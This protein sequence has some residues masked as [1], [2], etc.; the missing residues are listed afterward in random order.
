MKKSSKFIVGVGNLGLSFIELLVTMAIMAV[1]GTTVAGA[2]YISSKSYTRGA[3]EVNVQEEAQVALNLI[4][5]WVM[6][7]TA[8][9]SPDSHTLK[10]THPNEDSVNVITVYQDGDQLMY[11]V[12]SDP[13]A[14]VLCDY[15]ASTGVTFNSTFDT[16]RNVNV[17]VDFEI[18]GRTYHAAT[19]TTSRN[20][21]FTL[22]STG[23]DVLNLTVPDSTI[24]LEPGMNGDAASYVFNAVVYGATSAPTITLSD[25]SGDIS[26]AVGTVTASGSSV[27]TCPITV[28]SS[29][30]ASADGSFKLTASYTDGGATFSDSETI[31]TLVRRATKCVYTTND[32]G[33]LDPITGPTDSGKAGSVYINQVD[34][35]LT[36]SAPR[37]NAAYDSGTF[38]YVDPSKVEFYLRYDD[39]SA[40]DPSAY[41]LEFAD[42]GSP[43]IKV[44]LNQNITKDIK[45]YVS[46]VHSGSNTITGTNADNKASRLKATPT[47]YTGGGSYVSYFLIKKGGDDPINDVGAGFQRG[48]RAFRLGKLSDAAALEVSQF[49]ATVDPTHY[50]QVVSFEYKK[51]GDSTY[52]ERI[53]VGITPAEQGSDKWQ[54]WGNSSDAQQRLADIFDCDSAYSIRVF[55]DLVSED[56]YTVAKHFE[57][58]G[59]V[60]AADPFIYNNSDGKFVKE[61]SSSVGSVNQPIQIVKNSPNGTNFYVFFDSYNCITGDPYKITSVSGYVEKYKGPATRTTAELNDPNNWAIVYIDNNGQER[62]VNKPQIQGSESYE[63]GGSLTFSDGTTKPVGHFEQ[64][65]FPDIAVTVV[66]NECGA[67]QPGQNGLYRVTYSTLGGPT[68]TRAQI[69]SVGAMPSSSNP[70]GSVFGMAEFSSTSE[71]LGTVYY[72]IKNF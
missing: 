52:S 12:D 54:L 68:A 10:I 58:T 29:N 53:Y 72:E 65:D 25:Q 56:N 4:S 15:L 41:T 39:G 21:D 20:H 69:T 63:H 31:I 38:A 16:N 34:L 55:Y 46:S 60:N 11:K 8:V 23:S 44:T 27:Y 28:S 3:A 47:S 13:N 37:L 45:V 42:H 62:S 5:D 17:S 14:Y 32:Q 48:S 71:N 33:Y 18:K 6:D 50:L 24:V 57:S 22:N 26:A 7:A 67:Y 30:T 40:V 2:M 61:T 59:T 51:Q 43:Y 9:E 35:G 36:N 70:T 64:N 66:K 1:V 19:D 49:L